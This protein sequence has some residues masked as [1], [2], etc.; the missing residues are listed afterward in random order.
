MGSKESFI[1]KAFIAGSNPALPTIIFQKAFI[2]TM[3]AFLLLAGLGSR[4]CRIR[5]RGE[6]NGLSRSKA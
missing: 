2:T 5:D 1:L 4:H 3:S 6:A